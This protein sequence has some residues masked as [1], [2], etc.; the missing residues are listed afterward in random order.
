[1]I[2]ILFTEKFIKMVRELESSLRDDVYARVN[3]LRDEKNHQQF[4]VHKLHGKYKNF[5]GF[6]VNYR[7]R[8]VFEK[9]SSKKFLLHIVGGHEIYE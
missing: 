3:E 5:Y 4:K 8:I 7:I 2:D 9:L 6:S 1:M